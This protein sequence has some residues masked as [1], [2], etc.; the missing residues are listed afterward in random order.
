LAV[1]LVAAVGCGYSFSQGG[2][3]PRD[4]KALAVL[5]VN[6]KTAEAEAGGAFGGALRDELVARGQLAESADVPVVQL[7]LMALK[8]APSALSGA[9]AFAFRLDCDVRVHVRSSAGEPLFEDQV[10]LGEDYLGGEDVVETEADRRSALRRLSR[11]VAREV[12]DRLA[13]AGRFS[14]T[15]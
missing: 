10:V 14:A 1:G 7:D 15:K 11:A 12:L 2:R 3:L 8:S 5:P 13:A 4:A 9:G 6:N